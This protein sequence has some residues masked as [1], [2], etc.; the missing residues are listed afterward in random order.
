MSL[1]TSVLRLVIDASLGIWLGK[2]VFFSFVAAPK[3]FKVL[4][5]GRAGDVVNEIFPTYYLVGIVAGVVTFVAGVAL[6]ALT[7]YN[8]SLGVVLG[9]AAVG[10][11]IDVYARQVL[12]PRI[13]GNDS[14]RDDGDEDAFEQY[15]GLSVKLNAVALIVVSAS[16]VASHF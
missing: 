6:G 11:G 5:R 4:E 9:G 8:L 7:D 12:I 15:H 2:M 1:T 10:A 3:T 16:L 14:S 13:K